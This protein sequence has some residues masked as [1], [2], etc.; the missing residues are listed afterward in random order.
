[1]LGGLLSALPGSV[2]LFGSVARGEA[3]PESDIDLICIVDRVEERERGDI[4]LE[5]STAAAKACS[6][7]VDVIVADWARWL[8]WRSLPSTVEHRAWKEGTWLRHR[9]PDPETDWSNLM[10]PGQIRA[11]A[12]AASLYNTAAHLEAALGDMSPTALEAE[13]ASSGEAERYWDLVW[14][15]L[16][17]INAD[18]HI[19]LEQCFVALCHLIGAPFVTPAH[20]LQ[21]LYDAL[22]EYGL[23]DLDS[24][25]DGI[26]LAWVELWRSGGSYRPD[27][28]RDE[29]STAR[30]SR[31]AAVVA[32]RTAGLSSTL[33]TD[34]TSY[35]RTVAEISEAVVAI[36]VDRVERSDVTDT[37]DLKS[38]IGKMRWLTERLRERLD[39][40]GWL[41]PDGTPPHGW[42]PPW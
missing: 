27:L 1:M 17:R 32:D 34:T 42:T 18:L 22:T 31:T 35:S 3:T 37:E 5:L 16:G 15:R 21:P 28:T 7:P 23:E 14:N 30:L 40:S 36:V 38:G 13:A 8:S 33:V 12:V 29:E 19:A 20:R 11:A 9:P 6:R 26:D 39:D 4:G 41:Y 10:V 25:L 24:W 2:L